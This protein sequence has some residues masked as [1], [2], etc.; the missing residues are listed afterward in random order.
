ME[1]LAGIFVGLIL[2]LVALAAAFFFF[3]D[4][5]L[6]VFPDLF[7]NINEQLISMADQ[8]LGAKKDEIENLVKEVK[9]EVRRSEENR[10]SSFSAL[11]QA[12]KD[13]KETTEEL[14]KN[15]ERLGKVLSNN[16]LRG[17]WGE[18]VAEDLLRLAGF[19]NETDYIKNKKQ[20]ESDTRPDFTILLPE[21]LKINVDVKFPFNNLQEWQKS[22]DA[23]AK[24]NYMKLF[25]TD[26]K[27]K[28]KQIVSRNYINPADNTVDFAILFIPTE[29][30]FSFIYE[31]MND[32][33]LE[34]LEQKVI[35]AGPLN[36]TA[37]LRLIR[38]AH[39]NFRY[40]KNIYKIIKLINE[41]MEE[42]GKYNIEFEKLGERISSLSDQYQKVDIT[43]TKKLVGTVEKI[44]SEE[45]EELTTSEETLLEEPKILVEEN[46]KN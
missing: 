21:G 8:K 14:S 18:Q 4:K 11:T 3:R 44:K 37:I 38:Q 34:G 42:F 25:K 29:M 30:V 23:E 36:F 5:I 45:P 9:D 46:F 10:I 26:V 15:T 33:W 27:N 31:R 24:N 17:Q 1:L 19:V 40:Q 20:E 39:S 35:F 41:F 28:I 43:R 12:L 2:T 32:L 16:Q 22:E 7:K 13:Q 6:L